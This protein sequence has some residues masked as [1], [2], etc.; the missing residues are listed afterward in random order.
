M[1]GAEQTRVVLASHRATHA[2][3]LNPNRCYDF[4]VGADSALRHRNAGD[5]DWATESQGVV[6]LHRSDCLPS[7]SGEWLP[8]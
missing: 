3:E 6:V 1:M 2:L 4:A 7:I 8:H 5:M